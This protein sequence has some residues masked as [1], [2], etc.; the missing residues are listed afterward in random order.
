MA[1]SKTGPVCFRA[2]PKKFFSKARP[3]SWSMQRKSH[4]RC[5]GTEEKRTTIAS[6]PV[7]YRATMLESSHKSMY[8]RGSHTPLSII[9]SM[10]SKL[11]CSTSMRRWTGEEDQR[12]DDND[13]GGGE[14][15]ECGF[16][17]LKSTNQKNESTTP[18]KSHTRKRGSL[19]TSGVAFS[20]ARKFWK[21][22]QVQQETTST[23][24]SDSNN[25]GNAD[26]DCLQRGKQPTTTNKNKNKNKKHNFIRNSG[27]FFPLK[28]RRRNKTAITSNESSSDD[29]LLHSQSRAEDSVLNSQHRESAADISTPVPST[30]PDIT[31]SPIPSPTIAPMKFETTPEKLSPSRYQSLVHS[32]NSITK[33]WYGQ[34]NNSNDNNNTYAPPMAMEQKRVYNGTNN[35]YWGHNNDVDTNYYHSIFYGKRNGKLVVVDDQ[36]SSSSSA[37]SSSPSWTRDDDYDDANHHRIMTRKCGYSAFDCT[38]IVPDVIRE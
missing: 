20:K 2:A 30:T 34:N 16:S 22:K 27:S 5:G 32:Y 13:N 14:R 9:L 25:E 8:R 10:P 19:A 21:Q 29:L 38:S 33:D 12:D 37:S 3:Q 18:S 26:V 6:Q 15:G 11:M 35:D 4:S 23:T 31:N 28:G 17:K 1:T 24:M 36:D 7:E